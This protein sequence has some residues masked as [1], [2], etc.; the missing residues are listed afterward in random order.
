[1]SESPAV[2][3]YATLWCPYCQAAR[4]LLTSKGVNFEEIDLTEQ[5]EKRAEMQSRSG[6]T[7]VPQIFI[8][9]KHIGGF[10]DMQALDR[11]GE[12][13]PLLA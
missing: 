13:D 6:R 12:L 2:L 1:M 3:M 7:S 5:P 8:G 9:D 10:D 11:K 4:S